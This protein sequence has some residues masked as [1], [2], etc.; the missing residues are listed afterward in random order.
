[1]DGR[2]VCVKVLMDMGDVMDGSH[3][4][5]GCDVTDGTDVGRWG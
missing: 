5:D 3:G 2:N 4:W 1:M